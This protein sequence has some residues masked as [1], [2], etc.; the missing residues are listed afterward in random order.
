MDEISKQ[1]QAA[2]DR[3]AIEDATVSNEMPS[4]LISYSENTLLAR[5]YLSG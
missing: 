5:V 4:E 2:Y 1:V 3:L